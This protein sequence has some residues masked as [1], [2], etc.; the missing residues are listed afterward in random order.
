MSCLIVSKK[1]VLFHMVYFCCG[2]ASILI[3]HSIDGWNINNMDNISHLSQAN[4]RG[5]KNICQ[6]LDKMNAKKNKKSLR[7]QLNT[8]GVGTATPQEANLISKCCK[9]TKIMHREGGYARDLVSP[10]FCAAKAC[11]SISTIHIERRGVE[12][13]SIQEIKTF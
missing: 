4:L 7:C 1:A 3:L 13:I 12:I 6:R 2:F 10:S 5:V 8:E 9:N 11:P